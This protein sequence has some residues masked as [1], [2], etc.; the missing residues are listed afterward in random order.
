MSAVDA[1]EKAAAKVERYRVKLQLARD[2]LRKARDLATA[3][4]ICHR[5]CQ[6]I[7]VHHKWTF[8]EDGGITKLAHR[9]CDK[10][11]SYR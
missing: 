9:V 3:R 8:V 4:K 10:P 5:C 1:V 11:D 2:E 7:R 6:Q